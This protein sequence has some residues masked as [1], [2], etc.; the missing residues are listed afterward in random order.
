M[1]NNR[2][3]H[4]S[5]FVRLWKSVF[6][7]IA[8]GMPIY[9]VIIAISAQQSR[10][11][12][13]SLESFLQQITIVIFPT[14]FI[15][16]A[17]YFFTDL[18]VDNEG[19]LVDFFW[20]KLRIPWNKIIQIKPLFGLRIKK[21]GMYI[22][23]VDGLTPFHRFYGLLYG[24]TLKPAFILSGSVSNFEVLKN[25]IEKHIKQNRRTNS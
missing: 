4:N 8:F 19:L 12:F 20:K 1:D 10:L 22:V 24:F 25:D 14:P 15:L 3:H 2:Q 21:T 9:S 17:A 23:I 18:E 6:V 7:A 11:F 13:S 16:F 5:R